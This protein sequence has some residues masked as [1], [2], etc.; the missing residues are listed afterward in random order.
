VFRK[1]LRFLEKVT[2][3]T[4]DSFFDLDSNSPVTPAAVGE[5][6]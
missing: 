6:A 1:F 2:L 4:P 3:S 5:L